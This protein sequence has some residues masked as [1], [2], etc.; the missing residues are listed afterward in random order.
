MQTRLGEDTLDRIN[1]D[2]PSLGNFHT[3]NFFSDLSKSGSAVTLRH[4]NDHNSFRTGTHEEANENVIVL[5]RQKKTKTL[6][7]CLVCI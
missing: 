6:Q 4:L 3:E 5:K 1:I 7:E 2:D